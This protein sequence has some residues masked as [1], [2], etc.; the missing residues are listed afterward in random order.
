MS[1]L[2]Q[3][4]RII[5]SNSSF[6]DEICDVR[7]ENGIFTK[8]GK[9]LKKNDNEQV[10]D[11]QS[12]ILS[13]GFFDLNCHIGDPGFETKE[14]IF[15]ATEAASAGGFT[16]LAVSPNSHPIVQS[17]TEVQ[18]ILNK[19]VQTLTDIFPLGA[20]S[21]NFEGKEIA[22]L[23]DMKKAGA[24]AFS[25][26]T[27]P[28][29]DAGF[30]SRALQYAKGV[31]ALLMVQP[32]NKSIAGK[33]QINESVNSVLLGMKGNPALAEEMQI[34]RDL[35]LVNYHDAPIHFQNISTKGS[36]QLIK[37]AKQEGAKVTCEVAAHHLVFTEE[38]L[39]DFDSNYKVKPPLRSQE[40]VNAL[41]LGLKDGTIDAVCSQHTPHEIEFKN[42]EFEVAAYGIIGLQ[43]VLP[44]LIKA[45][46]NATEIV[47]KLAIA[48]RKIV[49]LP[50]VKI[51]EGEKANFT[52]FNTSEIWNYQIENNFSKSK[53]TPL[54]NTQLTGKVKFVCNKNQY[55]IYE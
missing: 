53:N 52:V 38:L 39:N 49:N 9:D 6:N 14:D 42:V 40:D 20:I 45:G 3:K 36:V 2:L 33:A 12:S 37:K 34:S 15:S 35:F 10:F 29:G 47:E 41:V 48:P 17:K 18:Y 25:E 11:M 19:S 31:G 5:D 7:V 4:V 32:E 27:K 55:K 13:P 51:E 43:T 46:L 26:G 8:I 28:I 16:A 24:I 22:E 54:L 30:M 21:Q 50:Q 1:F 23:Y 44:L